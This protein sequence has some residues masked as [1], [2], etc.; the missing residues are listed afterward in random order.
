ML[1]LFY[2]NTILAAP[3]RMIYFR[4]TSNGG[5]GVPTTENPFKD[6]NFL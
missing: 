1:N 2:S 6:S 3:T 4:E 5:V